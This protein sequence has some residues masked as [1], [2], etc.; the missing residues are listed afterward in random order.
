MTPKISVQHLRG[1]P[2]TML[3]PLYA[4][5]AETLRPQ[6]IIHDEMA[7][8]MVEQ[9]DY[10]F[11]AFAADVP[12]QLGIAI[13]TEILDEFTRD[14]ITRHPTCRII[15]L[16]AGL[17]TRLWRLDNEQLR[18]VDLDLPESIEVRTRFLPAHP[19]QQ[20]IAASAL[21]PAWMEQVENT[22]PTLIIAEGLFIYFTED[23][24]KDLMLA[25]QLRFP[26]AE[27]LVETIGK[28]LL[29]RADSHAS[30]ATTEAR[31]T[32]AIDDPREMEN[33]HPSIH[34]LDDV[35]IYD[36]YPERW[37]SLYPNLSKPLSALRHK[38]TRILHL[39]FRG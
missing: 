20:I 39:K 19:R 31:F 26:S 6:P 22:L 32:W 2:E 4:R 16:G 15:N 25:L 27:L 17:D 36:R 30:V 11:S 29:E 35:S 21:D 3:L 37:Q 33:W 12:T 14:F 23:S 24:V 28:H 1:V 13:R 34:L 7:V 38:V 5:A 8:Q 10:D 18:W 9:I